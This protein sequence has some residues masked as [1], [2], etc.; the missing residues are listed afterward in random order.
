[1]TEREKNGNFR[2]ELIDIDK[3]LEKLP[4]TDDNPRSDYFNKELI[5]AIKEYKKIK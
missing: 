5:E 2:L 3:A 1:M 4:T